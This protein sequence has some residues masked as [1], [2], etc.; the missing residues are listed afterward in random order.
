MADRAGDAHTRRVAFVGL[1]AMGAPMAASLL[2]AGHHV[3]VVPHRSRAAADALAAAGARVAA[4][5]A[6]AACDAE[7]VVT[8]LPGAAE[9][10]AVLLGPDGVVGAAAEGTLVVDMST[11]GPT[12]ARMLGE[13]LH[14]AGLR[15]VDA[16]VSGGPAR[17][18]TGTLTAIVGGEAATLEAARPVLEGMAST[19]FHAGPLGA[20]QVAKACNNLLVAACMLA[21]AEALALGA[22]EGLAPSTLREIVLASSGAN[23]QLENIVPRTILADDFTPLFAMPLLRKD[24]GIAAEMAD[25]SGSAFLVGSL[26]RQAYGLA[27]ALGGQELDFSAVVKIYETALGATSLQAAAQ[28]RQGA[29]EAGR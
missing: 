7:V 23:W 5:P 25:G 9:V 13:R 1:G 21:N 29:D 4:T 20:G 14:T 2:R 18:E 17:A 11:I 19:I 6:E 15:F 8:M 12:P 28:A 27:A 10:E 26:A 22:A 3:T 16:P 24:L